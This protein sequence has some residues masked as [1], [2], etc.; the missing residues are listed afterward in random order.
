MY[1]VHHITSEYFHGIR[2]EANGQEVLFG[3]PSTEEDSHIFMCDLSRLLAET[4]RIAEENTLRRGYKEFYKASR[5]E[6]L[7]EF[8]LAE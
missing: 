6:R 3:H 4:H 5:A 1:S 2:Y 7:R 8:G